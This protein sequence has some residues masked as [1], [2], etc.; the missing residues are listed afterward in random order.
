[1]LTATIVLEDTILTLTRVDP[2]ALWHGFVADALTGK[3]VE[4]LWTD[5]EIGAVLALAFAG[6]DLPV[7]AVPDLYVIAEK[8]IVGFPPEVRPI[9]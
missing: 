2:V 5:R 9:P 3:Q 1:M 8:A 4:V 7:S 6:D